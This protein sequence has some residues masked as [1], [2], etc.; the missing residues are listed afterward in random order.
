MKKMNKK[1]ILLG[2]LLLVLSGSVEVLGQCTWVNVKAAPYGAAGDGTTDDTTA[3]QNALDATGIEKI[4]FPRGI[5]KVTSTLTVDSDEHVN[6]LAGAGATIVAHFGS[7]GFFTPILNA[8]KPLTLEGLAFQPDSTDSTKFAPSWDN[9]TRTYSYAENVCAPILLDGSQVYR[10]SF[11]SFDRG[12][13]ING[14]DLSSKPSIVK[15]CHFD[16]IAGGNAGTVKFYL[17]GHG[18]FE[19][20]NANLGDECVFASCKEMI[21]R[22]NNLFLPG[23]PAIDVGGSAASLCEQVIIT[24]NISTGRDGIVCELGIKNVVIANNVLFPT[25]LT[26]NGVGVGI[27]TASLGQDIEN[28]IIANN[29]VVSY[30]NEDGAHGVYA[31]GISVN[32]AGTGLDA[33]NILIENNKTKDAL[34]GVRVKGYSPSEKTD[35][36]VISGNRLKDCGS[37][38][39]ILIN[40][41][42]GR[43]RDNYA[44]KKGTPYGSGTRGAS[45]N[46]VTNVKAIGNEFVDFNACYVVVGN[47]DGIEII[48]PINNVSTTDWGKIIDEEDVTGGYLLIKDLYFNT[49]PTTGRIRQGSTIRNY[50]TKDGQPTGWVCVESGTGGGYFSATGTIQGAAARTTN[51]T[52]NTTTD[53]GKAFSNYGAGG[54]ITFTLPA[55]LRNLKYTFYRLSNAAVRIDPSGTEQI[56][57]GSG[58][59]KYI[60]LDSNGASI[61]LE[62]SDAGIWESVSE[63]GSISNE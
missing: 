59:G 14:P 15:D 33:Q 13:V 61:S 32:L 20:N 26:P 47:L 57:G 37:Y 36:V 53:N 7:P 60:Q 54:T 24:D 3:I 31:V 58:A 8:S 49:P 29:T 6:E 30:N 51:Y 55:G 1:Q 23:T 38:G 44:N 63:Y 62:W 40:V 5:Y 18:I 4:W 10:C 9:P 43:V 35:D 42:N 27:S 50:A 46:T 56:R 48:S 22:G 45:L 2:I 12:L 17:V 16:S 25:A 11:S 52:C 28:V 34:Y 39:V 19:G 21:I 41:S